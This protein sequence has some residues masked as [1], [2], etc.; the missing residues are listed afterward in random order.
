MRG[1]Q[2]S[3]CHLPRHIRPLL[4]VA[5]GSAGLLLFA[6]PAAAANCEAL[7]SAAFPNTTVTAAQIVPAGTYTP[8]GQTTSYTALPEFCRVTATI[9]PVPGSKIGIEEW[10]PTQNWNGRYQ[11]VG[12]HGLAGI[13]H[14]E[15]LAPQL[16]MGFA[17]AA[18]DMGHTVDA[19]S[20]FGVNWYFSGG[21]ETLVDFAWRSV[22]ELSIIG[23]LLIHQFYGTSARYA[24]FNGCSD[25]GREGFKSAQMFPED[26][27]GILS[28]GA[29]NYYTRANAEQLFV[30]VELKQGGIQGTT[31]AATMTLSQNAATA[32]CDSKDGVTDGLIRDPRTCHWS[33]WSLICSAGQ[34]SSTC[35]TPNQAAALAANIAPMRDPVTLAWLF[36]GMSR[37]SEFDQIRFGYENG[38]APYGV[39]DFQIAHQ[40]PNWDGSTFN[41]H[42]DVPLLDQTFGIANA[43]NPDMR[44][45]KNLGGKIIEWH[46]WDDAAFTPGFTAA[47]YGEVVNKTGGKDGQAD[48]KAVRHASDHDLAETQ[49]FFRLFMMPGV[50]HCGGGPGPADI[51]AEGQTALQHDAQHDAVIALEDWVERGQP[52][53]KFIATKF[54]NDDPTQGIAMQR[55]ICPY[56]AEAV[57]KGSGDTND[58]SSFVCSTP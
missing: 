26:F 34:D 39:A 48:F 13:I 53:K 41:L 14:Y 27:D 36:S 33:P 2:S 46:G 29:A 40:D 22:H 30:S 49:D 24:Y 12:N 8:P 52:P 16:R 51:G 5:A 10:L 42:T 20:S 44:P 37:G 31:G 54:T 11:Q 23:K 47:F 4:S 43:I 38:L 25:G 21:P 35:F 19:T 1:N 28:G 50:G 55:P 3:V 9:S 57:Y 17:T 7:A 6:Q 58:A 56:P 32:Q 45:F 18:T 15:E